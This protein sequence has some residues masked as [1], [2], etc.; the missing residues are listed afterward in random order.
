MIDTNIFKY[1]ICDYLFHILYIYIYISNKI[2]KCIKSEVDQSD[3]SEA[4][5]SKI[6]RKYIFTKLIVR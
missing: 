3:F 5:L 2:K 4:G 1:E 6:D